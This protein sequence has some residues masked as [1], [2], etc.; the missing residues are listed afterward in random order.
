MNLA[1]TL[2]QLFINQKPS[3]L[4]SE[5]SLSASQSLVERCKAGESK[6]QFELYKQYA[7]AMYSICLRISNHETEAEDILQEAFVA[8]FR[9][10]N[11]FRNDSTFGAWLK[12]IVVNTAINYVRKRR[13]E[14]VPMENARGLEDETEKDKYKIQEEN[15]QIEQVKA[16]I[17]KLP[18]G[19][20]VVLSLYLLEGY[21]HAEIA[22]VLGI[23]ESTSK[24][25][26]N[27]AKTKLREFLN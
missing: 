22:E 23:S 25:Q 7:K 1:L 9:K 13:M 6:A 26:Y 16:A 5:A 2:N 24:S 4:A 14:L 8:A 11:E 15:Y 20:R 17:R 12:K 3:Y 19:F 10:I 18:D 21:D 27:R